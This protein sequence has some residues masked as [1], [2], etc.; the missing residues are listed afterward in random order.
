MSHS[1]SSMRE[2]PGR[3]RTLRDDAAPASSLPHSRRHFTN[4]LVWKATFVSLGVGSGWLG[5]WRGDSWGET[6]VWGGPVMGGHIPFSGGL[7]SGVRKGWWAESRCG[8]WRV[9]V[10]ASAWSV[11][12][13]PVPGASP[14]KQIHTLQRFL[15]FQSGET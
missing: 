10:P 7:L 4:C 14:A 15:F 8:G 1:S 3:G 11:K 2:P 13:E 5:R 12:N 9:D 6:P